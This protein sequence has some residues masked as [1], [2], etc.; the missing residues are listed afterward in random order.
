MIRKLIKWAISPIIDEAIA[1]ERDTNT[2]NYVNQQVEGA[3][4]MCQE[5][6]NNT[7]QEVRIEMGMIRDL[8]TK[9]KSLDLGGCIKE[10]C[11]GRL[12][13]IDGSSPNTK[14]DK[15]GKVYPF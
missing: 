10:G 2:R 5:H 15:C 14:C 4:G 8:Q 11:D 1:T 12:H 6:A 13:G 7:V 9:A 3:V